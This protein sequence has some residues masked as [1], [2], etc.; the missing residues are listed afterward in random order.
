MQISTCCRSHSSAVEAFDA[1]SMY[2]CARDMLERGGLGCF[3]TRHPHISPYDNTSI[4][5]DH[6]DDLS[7]V[8]NYRSQQP[9]LRYEV[10][11]SWRCSSIWREKCF[12]KA[13]LLDTNLYVLDIS[14]EWGWYSDTSELCKML[15]PRDPSWAVSRAKGCL[16]G[17]AEILECI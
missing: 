16:F 15:V 4:S 8:W 11:N 7:I 17:S 9:R 14:L 2:L 3:R 12:C 6:I 1:H 5:K 10:T 13:V